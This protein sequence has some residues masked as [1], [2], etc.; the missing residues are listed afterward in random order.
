MILDF[1]VDKVILSPWA[2]QPS[3]PPISFS[4]NSVIN[5]FV[6]YVWAESES[7]EENP[8]S[9][10]MKTY[11]V[12]WVLLISPPILVCVLYCTVI[13]R[14]F[15][16]IQTYEE[17]IVVNI[18]NLTTPKRDFLSVK[19]VGEGLFFLCLKNLFY[20]YIRC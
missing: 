17:F 19:Y 10:K 16:S 20:H 11:T 14:V 5:V 2:L 1:W 7:V 18:C 13:E 4:L 8:F 12:G 15:F 3:K 6:G 9:F